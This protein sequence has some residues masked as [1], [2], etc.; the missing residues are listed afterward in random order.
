[1]ED[2]RQREEGGIHHEDVA[3][4]ARR[5][6]G[7]GGNEERAGRPRR[8]GEPPPAGLEDRERGEQRRVR[9][10]EQE[11][12]T[13]AGVS[14]R[15]ARGK[16]DEKL[17]DPFE[18]RGSPVPRLLDA[19]V[20]ARLAR[21]PSRAEDPEKDSGDRREAGDRGGKSGAAAG[22]AARARRWRVSIASGMAMASAGSREV[23][24]RNPKNAAAAARP[25][26][27]EPEARSASSRKSDSEYI[28]DEEEGGRDRG[29]ERAS[30]S[31]PPFSPSRRR[32]SAAKRKAGGEEAERRRRS[33]P[34]AKASTEKSRRTP[35][36]AIG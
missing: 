29:A 24:A 12:R 34:A 19:E 26:S 11:R 18:R 2:L 21:Q 13:L 30:A 22:S 8:V 17:A 4:K 32:P 14:P 16:P 23:P 5:D 36:T 10:V 28:A 15:D 33:V 3:R 35:R 6:P 7:R 31:R 27:R 25:L 1:M 20:E 9:V